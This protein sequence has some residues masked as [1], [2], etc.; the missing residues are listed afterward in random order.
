MVSLTLL[1]D[2]RYAFRQLLKSPGFTLTVVLT[3]AL[4]IG[5]NTAIFSLFNAFVLR[6][7]PAKDPA[8]IVNVYRTVESETRY[9]V[10]SYPEY[11]NY[12][13]HNTAFSG[14]AAFTGGR[15]TLTSSST[16]NL[17]NGAAETLQAQLVSGNYFSMLGV[18]AER[19]RTFAAEE[20]RTP[21]AEPVAV[22]S[23]RFWKR[24]FDGDPNV[25]GSRLTLNSVSY[26]VIGIAPS[27]FEGTVPDPPDVWVPMMMQGNVRPGANL[28]EDRDYMSLQVLG[29]L[30]P[31]VRREQAQA[32]LTVLARQFA[33][34]GEDKNHEVSVSVTPGKFL[35]PEELGDVL[36]LAVLVMTAVGLVLLIA[37]ANVANLLLARGAGRQREIGIRLSLGATRRRLVRQLLTESMLLALGGGIGGLILAVWMADL[38][39]PSTKFFITTH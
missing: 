1:H 4:G 36:P 35:T 13:D 17:G 38:R 5:G 19:G 31:G 14:L 27:E 22:L 23:Y 39:I 32:E 2:L 33:Q 28:L 12:R 8:R 9:G 25:V 10:F 6:P 37:C 16:R 24:R 20:D 21:N 15:V 11:I 3:L 7:I 34:P 26:T 29:R 30:K 18:P